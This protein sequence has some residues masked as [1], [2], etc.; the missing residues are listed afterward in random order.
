MIDKAELVTHICK[1]IGITRKD[2]KRKDFTK[3]ELY[4]LNAYITLKEE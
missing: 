1:Q 3:E 4:K 2:N